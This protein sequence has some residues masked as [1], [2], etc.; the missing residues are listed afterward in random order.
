MGKEI[1]FYSERWVCNIDIQN[2][3]ADVL[4]DLTLKYEVMTNDYM[5]NSSSETTHFR[6]SYH[7]H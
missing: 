7:V 5:A 2:Q 4:N 6:R 3:G 1:W